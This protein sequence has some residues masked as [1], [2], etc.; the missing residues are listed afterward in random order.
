MTQ[1][2]LLAYSA[3]GIEDATGISGPA[4][5]VLLAVALVV[6]LG[7]ARAYRRRRQGRR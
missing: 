7:I 3:S 1:K 6:V 4:L 2:N 5:L